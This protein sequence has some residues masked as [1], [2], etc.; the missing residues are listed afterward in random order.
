MSEMGPSPLSPDSV[1][2]VQ[3]ARAAAISMTANAASA[4][5]SGMGMGGMGAPMAGMMA[6]G[7]LAASAGK[8]IKV[9][10]AGTKKDEDEDDKDLTAIGA[11]GVFM[12]D[13]SKPVELPDILTTKPASDKVADFEN[14]DASALFERGG[15]KGAVAPPVLGASAEL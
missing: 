11:T 12:G 8:G 2:G 13:E 10:N 5:G 6:G 3:S 9:G 15:S 4:G 14:V 1:P 7:A